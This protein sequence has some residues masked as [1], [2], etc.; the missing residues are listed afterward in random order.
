MTLYLIRHANAGSR[1]GWDADDLDRPLSQRG[2]DQ[3]DH[4]MAVLDGSLGAD[5]QVWSSPALRCV[6][7]VQPVA[8]AHGTEVVTRPELGEG[9][10]AGRALS[11]LLDAAGDAD[12]VACSHGDI[13]PRA[14]G[15]LVADGLHI[16]GDEG[17]SMCKK[18]S[19]WAIEVANGRG[20]T[21]RHHPPGC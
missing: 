2:R 21:A 6:Q 15:L 12:V 5:V 4:L 16:D 13:I 11:L 10:D 19:M 3:V 14:M 17:P 7:T 9:L 18:G 20:V 8:A 1:R